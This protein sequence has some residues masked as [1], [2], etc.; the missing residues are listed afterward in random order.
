MFLNGILN[1]FTCDSIQCCVIYL[2]YIITCLERLTDRGNYFACLQGQWKCSIHALIRFGLLQ[3]GFWAPTAKSTKWWMSQQ[4]ACRPAL[5][6]T[7]DFESLTCDW[8][9]V[10]LK[11]CL[12]FAAEFTRIDD[13][14]IRNSEAVMVTIIR[15]QTKIAR[16]SDGRTARCVTLCRLYSM[17]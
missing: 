4:G 15:P 17:M 9:H 13:G 7:V 12:L 1:Y 16:P 11:K 8:T 5:A 3:T 2:W 6:R 10:R 14:F